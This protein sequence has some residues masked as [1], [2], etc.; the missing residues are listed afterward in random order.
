MTNVSESISD[1]R[2][3]TQEELASSNNFDEFFT[4]LISKLGAIFTG[5]LAT[6]KLFLIMKH[7][8]D[9]SHFNPIKQHL[10]RCSPCAVHMDLLLLNVKHLIPLSTHLHAK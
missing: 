8:V 1:G 7:E 6:Q 5:I 3:E 9:H 10:I 2:S 4:T